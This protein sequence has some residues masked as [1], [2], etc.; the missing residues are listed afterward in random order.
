MQAP[1]NQYPAAL[2]PYGDRTIH[3]RGDQQRSNAPEAEKRPDDRTLAIELWLLEKYTLTQSTCTIAAYRAILLSLRAYLQAQGL[4]LDQSVMTLT[5]HIQTWAG[6]R[7]SASKRQGHV[8]PTTY[9]QRVAA[10]SSFYQW[11]IEN[12]TYVGKNPTDKVSRAQ[13]KKYATSCALNPQEIRMKLKAIDCETPQGLRDYVLLQVALNTG[14]SSQELASLTW[15]CVHLENGVVTLTFKRCKG[16]KTLHD[17]LEP[18][19]SQV[20]LKYLGAIYGPHLDTL[21][22]DTPVWVSF[23]DRNYNRAIGPQTIADI[24]EKH[25]GVSTVH[26][27]RHTFA[28]AMEQQGAQTSTIQVRLGH[29][30]SAETTVY[31]N[32][33]KQSSSFR[34]SGLPED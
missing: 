19:L 28:L 3:S 17:M 32:R 12:G 1:Y 6:L 2:S 21:A 5:A 30:S 13:V 14:H 10:V 16:G 25:L 22:L 7:A 24:C 15:N 33:L 9:N 4:D 29:T 8:A 11:A 26:T 18:R 27:L 23:S 20:L 31:L 34:M